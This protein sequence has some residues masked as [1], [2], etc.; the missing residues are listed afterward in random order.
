MDACC[1]QGIRRRVSIPARD[2]S[3]TP[4]SASVPG[5]GTTST[6]KRWVASSPWSPSPAPPRIVK[7]PP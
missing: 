3:P 7:E 4:A 1:R 2:S 6:V 5:S